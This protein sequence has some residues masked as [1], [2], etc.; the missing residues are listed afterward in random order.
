M[1]EKRRKEARSLASPKKAALYSSTDQIEKKGEE[2]F[3]LVKKKEQT[4]KIIGGQK[5]KR[6]ESRLSTPP[7]KPVCPYMASSFLPFPP[8]PSLSCPFPSLSLPDP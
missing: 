7:P 2:I 5:R 6:E 3:E 1:K 4:H 8:C